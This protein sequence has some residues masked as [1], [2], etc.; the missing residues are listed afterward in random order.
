MADMI[1][2][3]LDVDPGVEHTGT[4]MRVTGALLL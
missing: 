1:R 3:L 2:E 4:D